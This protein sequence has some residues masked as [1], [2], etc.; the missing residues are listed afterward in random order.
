MRVTSFIV[1]SDSS[2]AATARLVAAASVGIAGAAEQRRAK[3]RRQRRGRS[4]HR[5]NSS[6][7]YAARL[8]AKRAAAAASRRRLRLRATRQAVQADGRRLARR[9]SS[10]RGRMRRSS[11]AR[12]TGCP[13]SPSCS[14]RARARR[15]STGRARAGDGRADVGARAAPRAAGAGDRAGDRRPRR[16]V[17]ARAGDGGAERL[18]RPRARCR[19]SPTHPRAACPMPSRPGFIA[20][21]LG[22]HGARRAQLQLRHRPDPALRPRAPA[23]PRARRAGRG[24][25]ALRARRWSRRSARQTAEGYVFRVDLRLRPASEVS[26]LAIPFD[27]ALTPLRKLGAGVGA[28]RL[29]PRPR[30]RPATSRRARRFL[31]AIRPF[32]WRRSLDFGAIAEIRRLTAR[33]RDAPSRAARAGPGLR[34]QARARRHPRDRVLRPD[35]PADPRRA[36][37][38]A[39]AAR[40]PRRARCAGRGG[41]RSAPRMRE[42]LGEAYDRLR[43]IEHRLQMVADQQT[44]TLPAEPPRSTASPGST[45]WPTARRWSP[46]C[47]AITRGGRRRATTRCSPTRATAAA[48]PRRATRCARAGRLGFASP[49]ARRA[50]R[51]LATGKIRALRSEAA[52]AAFDAIQPDLLAALRRRAR[53]RAGA[54]PLGDAARPPAER[55]QP[56][57]PARERARACSSCS[58]RILTLAPPLAD[59]LARR[60][61]L[62]DPLIDAQRLRPARQRSRSSPR[63]CGAAR[64]ATTTSAGSTASA[65]WSASSASRSACS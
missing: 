65:G 57:P 19:A 36:Q 51:R 38:G 33:I 12:S 58:L 44:H 56:V 11:R 35:P 30:L 37:P 23:P 6:F 8:V 18:R 9:R 26:P 49:S 64:P 52:R 3:R 55:G 39:A 24:G 28:R 16:R 45:A 53:A 48:V 43:T 62:L 34:P 60:A 63:G 1:A 46:S 17:P 10:G 42:L 59:E 54:G 5:G 31:A 40:H 41:D 13:S 15:R 4:E 32:V 20:L 27:A 50:D 61:D 47:A 25:A 2:P 7:G 22:K 29:H 14:R 21:A